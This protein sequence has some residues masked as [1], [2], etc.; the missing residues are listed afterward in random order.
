MK[1]WAVGLCCLAAWMC[2][3]AYAQNWTVYVPPERDFRVL[4][5]EPPQRSDEGSG[6]V[7]F[8]ARADEI[9]YT[10]FRHRGSWGPSED[11]AGLVEARL[12]R[13]LPE[14]TGV[15]RMREHEEL[16]PGQYVFSIR[17]RF[18]IHRMVRSPFGF[19]ELSVR[20]VEGRRRVAEQTAQDFFDTFQASGSGIFAAISS[21]GAAVDQFCK[22]RTDVFSR[23]FCELRKCFY[24]GYEK[25]PICT[26]IFGR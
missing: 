21:I 8:R 26:T 25:Q 5:P 1:K 3:Y 18:S 10:V 7:A 9:E 22:D 4:F 6:V 2:T 15:R 16:T 19:Y 11:P 20:A 14:D 23:T 17:K 12:R 24:S 13:A